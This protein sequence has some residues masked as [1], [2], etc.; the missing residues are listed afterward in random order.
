MWGGIFEENKIKDRIKK[1]DITILDKDFWKDKF[2]AQKILKEKNFYQK[3]YNEYLLVVNDLQNL[4][5][6][7]DLA[8]VENDSSVLKDCEKK[9][10]FL[11][12]KNKKNWSIMFFIWRKRPFGYIFRNSCRSRWYGKSRLGRNVKKNVFKMDRETKM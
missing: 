11:L 12:K 3:V 7:V 8:L 4:E 1:F 5:E 9:T 10:I 6:L 2:K